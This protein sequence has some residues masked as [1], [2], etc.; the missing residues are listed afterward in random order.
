MQV[1]Y[2]LVSLSETIKTR[3][4]VYGAPNIPYLSSRYKTV[5][6]NR[7]NISK[8]V[9]AEK[10]YIYTVQKCTHFKND[11]LLYTKKTNNK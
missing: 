9:T 8:Q 11:Y 10:L 5:H 2:I 7:K 1:Y 3:Y 6:N 4:R